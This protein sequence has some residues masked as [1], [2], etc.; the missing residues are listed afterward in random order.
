M[1][2]T[3]QALAAGPR[4]HASGAAVLVRHLHGSEFAWAIA[5]VVSYAVVFAAFVVY[6]DA[7]GL[8]MASEVSLYGNLVANPL[9]AQTVINTALYVGPGVNVKVFLAL[10]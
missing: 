8:W 3:P 1:S 10:P 2:S 7:Y 4:A 5:F 6:P 9:Y